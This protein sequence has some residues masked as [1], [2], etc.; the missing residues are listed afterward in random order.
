MGERER[1]VWERVAGLAA[2]SI[3]ANLDAMRRF[4]AC[5]GLIVLVGCFTL[6]IA[7]NDPA[8]LAFDR[9]TIV[10]DAGHGG[11]DGGAKSKEALEKELTLQL[12]LRLQKVLEENGFPTVMTRTDDTYLSLEERVAIA[13][14]V[15]GPSLFVSVHFNR[16]SAGYINGI[17]TYYA[18][19]KVPGEEEWRWVGFF[20]DDGRLDTGEELAAEVQ[21]E[22]VKKTGARDRGIRP[23]RFYVTRFT[24]APA[25]LIE[26]GFLT[27]RMEAALLRDEAYHQRLAN[28]IAKGIRRWC[29]SRDLEPRRDTLVRN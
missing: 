25:V 20:N 29:A 2:D 15:K 14:A 24:R 11:V 9:P 5:V 1:R 12:A 8:E 17:E 16:G 21:Q 27:N 6:V 18:K 7:P 22:L 28:G 3:R 10:I 26:A 19:A 4:F 13:N 23:S